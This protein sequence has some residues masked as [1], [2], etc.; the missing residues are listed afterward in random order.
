MPAPEREAFET[1]AEYRQARRQWKR[2][3]GESYFWSVWWAFFGE[4][5]DD[6]QPSREAA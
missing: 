3:S 5:E 2:E 6:E 4:D 1:R